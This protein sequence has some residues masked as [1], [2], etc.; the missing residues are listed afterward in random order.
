MP[1]TRLN[2]RT[3]LNNPAVVGPLP[4]LQPYVRCACGKCRECRDN[5][6]WDRIFAKFA[7][8]DHEDGRR[9]SRSPLCDL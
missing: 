3:F 9:A 4:P 7:V 8:S 6:K 2:A 5:E 1:R